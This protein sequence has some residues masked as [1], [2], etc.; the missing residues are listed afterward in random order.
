MREH[1]THIPRI[2][3][4]LPALLLATALAFSLPA[5]DA[6][7]AAQ[8]PHADAKKS[9]KR[10]KKRKKANKASARLTGI[11]DACSYSDPKL[12]PLPDCGDRLLTLREGG[13]Q[14]VLNYWSDSMSIE[15]NVRYA[16]QA[17]SL[18]MQVIWNLADYR[19]P[20]APKLDLV[21]VTKDHPATWG[22]YI[23]DEVQPADRDQVVQLSGAIRSL[24]NRPLLYVSRP[25]PSKLRPFNGLANYIGPDIYPVGPVDR[26]SVCRTARWAAKMLKGKGRLTMVLQAYSWSI[27]SPTLNPEWP[28][29]GQMRTMRSYWPQLTQAG[30][31]VNLNPTYRMSSGG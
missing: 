11:Y 14:T 26:Q 28:S 10:H 7:S 16:N 20:L 8:K 5:A 21:N 23:G 24:T 13:F 15:D 25:N 29:A 1:S 31:G 22:Y 6:A 18:G 2:G 27:D 4:L 30:N 19:A 17:H 3:R 12:T 9:G